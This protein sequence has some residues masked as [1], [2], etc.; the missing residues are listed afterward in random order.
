[1]LDIESS[2][3]LEFTCDANALGAAKFHRAF[4]FWKML[5]LE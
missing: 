3:T 2:Q 1:M 5:C 4:S